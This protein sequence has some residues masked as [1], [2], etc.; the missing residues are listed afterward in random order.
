MPISLQR[1]NS[2]PEM[3]AYS[4]ERHGSAGTTDALDGGVEWGLRGEGRKPSTGGMVVVGRC[5]M[6]GGFGPGRQASTGA[7]HD[8][9]DEGNESVRAGQATTVVHCPARWAIPKVA[10]RARLTAAA[11]RPKS[12]AIFVVPRT[13]ARR[14]P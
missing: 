4:G 6:L 13:R 3:S 2:A 1:S 7:R 11:S 9:N 14:P 12:V 8:G 5:V 10:R